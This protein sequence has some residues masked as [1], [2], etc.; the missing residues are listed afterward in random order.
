MGPLTS[1]PSG[2]DLMHL[3]WDGFFGGDEGGR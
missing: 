2:R 1:G 3:G